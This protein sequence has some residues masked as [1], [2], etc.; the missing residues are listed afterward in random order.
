MRVTA[1]AKTSLARR[2]VSAVPASVK[3]AAKSGINNASK[4]VLSAARSGVPE[5]TKSL[6]KALGR[7][8][9]VYN[10]AVIMLVGARRDIKGKPRRFAREVK[11]GRRAKSQI[12]TPAKYISLVNA[13]TRPHAIGKGSSLSRG[14]KQQS[15]SMHP[16]TPP[17]PFMLRAWLSTENQSR[18]AVLAE[19]PEELRR[20]AARGVE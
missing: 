13:G 20:G 5:D 14:G 8:I 11:R 19:V 3:K 18:R 12:V 10:Q 16:G 17:N 6:K 4:L 2:A 9:R 7:K 15:G 1:K